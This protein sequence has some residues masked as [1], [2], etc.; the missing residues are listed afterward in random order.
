MR[1][2]IL[3]DLGR[4]IGGAEKLSARIRDNL[5]ARGHDAML[6]TSTADVMHRTQPLPLLADATCYG[7]HGP[8]QRVLQVAN[9]A[10][11]VAVRRAL[12]TFRPDVVHVRMF[13]SQLSPL[14]LPLLR[15]TPSLL[16]VVNYLPI[17]PLDTKELP[18]GSPCRSRAGMACRGNGC[19]PLIGGVRVAV[20]HG[21]MRRWLG[22]FDRVLANS[23]WVQRRLLDD[24]FRC[25]GHVWNGVAER[26][27]RPPL[28]GLPTIG[29]AGRL[30]EKKGVSVL[31]QAFARVRE[32]CPEARLLVA[33]DGPD[34]P[35]L[36][37]R[38]GELQVADA[39]EFAG[40]LSPEEM[41]AR[42]GTAWVQAVPGLWEEPFGLVVAEAMMRGTAVVT[43]AT[44]GPA[45]QVVEG[46]T[47]RLVPPGD[48][49]ALAE[50]LLALLQ[51]VSAAEAM[52]TAGR[53]RALACFT[54]R[55]FM[56]RMLE[57]YEAISSA[58]GG[59][60]A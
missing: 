1:V 51:D 23:R 42:L 57:T 44:G 15:G 26:P 33:G 21:L 16:H 18:D 6:L 8:L 35:R 3:H 28:A 59:T 27:A 22:A 48:V 30:I 45:E 53:G 36:E 11:A 29:F 39:V 4:P 40:H 38:A 56:N 54:E 34:R 9:P 46:E 2:L 17:C 32:A 60:S 13:L 7:T 58:R 10:A 24:G 52:G 5:R 37:Q 43:T 25:D 41:E 55:V 20:Q 31:L 49:N 14:V 12:R 50:A 47:G 19:M